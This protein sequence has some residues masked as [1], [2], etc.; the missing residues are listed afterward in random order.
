[1]KT[2]L[3][4]SL[5]VLLAGRAHAAPDAAFSSALDAGRLSILAGASLSVSSEEQDM[6]DALNDDKPEVRI[7]AFKG[8]KRYVQYSDK[9]RGTA[10]AH[11]GYT[12]EDAG[13]RAEA[14]RALSAAVA[15]SDV[16]D[17]LRKHAKDSSGP[18]A[19]RAMCWKALYW[20]TQYDADVR[21]DALDAAKRESVETVRLAAIWSLMYAG[22]DAD[23]RSALLDLAKRDSSAAVRREA[24][25]SLYSEMTDSDVRSY[26]RDTALKGAGE[27]RYV[28]IM[29]LSTRMFEEDARL[30][31]DIAKNDADAVARRYA[32]T[33][34]AAPVQEVVYFFHQNHYQWVGRINRLISEAIDRE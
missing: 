15:D 26:A 13:V 11:L 30:L 3:C 29:M 14:A 32:V 9:A 23:V 24:A 12:S 33:A 8:L 7:Q 21:R 28:A 18:A 25:K 10:L 17:A 31:Q 27:A 22:G 6:L 34:L 1:M 19:V 4:L 2:T 20:Q 5:L 16:R